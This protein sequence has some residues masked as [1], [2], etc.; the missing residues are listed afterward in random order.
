MIS[1]D[2]TKVKNLTCNK[3]YKIKSGKSIEEAI[4]DINRSDQNLKP[5]T[6]HTT[7]ST[8]SDSYYERHYGHSRFDDDG[9]CGIGYGYGCGPY[10]KKFYES[11][12]NLAG[13][14]LPKIT[15]GS[16]SSTSRDRCC[17]NSRS[18]S[19]YRLARARHQ[20]RWRAI[21]G[22]LVTRQQHQR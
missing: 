22:N 9:G 15:G 10:D 11:D 17:Y 13:S 4:V 16:S 19:Y 8:G 12:K 3:V 21:G 2:K 5:V 14:T 18:A 1:G 20:S 7:Y 6:T